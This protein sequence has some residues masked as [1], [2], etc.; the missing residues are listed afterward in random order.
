MALRCD[1]G[2]AENCSIDIVSR[3]RLS[4]QINEE[5]MIKSL[6]RQSISRMPQWR[7]QRRGIEEAMDRMLPG[8]LASLV[9]LFI[10]VGLATTLIAS[11]LPVIDKL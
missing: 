10:C 3:L 2:R 1:N 4:G 11:V 7:G 8:N 6:R 9:R 5:N